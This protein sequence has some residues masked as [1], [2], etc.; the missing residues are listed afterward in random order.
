MQNSKSL[1]LLMTAA[2]FWLIATIVSVP[3]AL[4]NQ[5]QPAAA[6]AGAQP[7]ATASSSTGTGAG[8]NTAAASTGDAGTNPNT[9]VGTTDSVTASADSDGKVMVKPGMPIRV[10]PLSYSSAKGI[11]ARAT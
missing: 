4:A 3:P 1:K 10:C 9:A 6:A 11:S 7:T 8:A 5:A 2:G